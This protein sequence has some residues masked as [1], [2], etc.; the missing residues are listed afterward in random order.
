MIRDKDL[1][2]I[3]S[4]AIVAGLLVAWATGTVPGGDRG[5]RSLPTTSAPT[6]ST[7]VVPDHGSPPIDCLDKDGRWREGLTRE[8]IRLCL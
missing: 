5:G 6:T 3:G 2:R 1:I 8:E 4:V 7:V